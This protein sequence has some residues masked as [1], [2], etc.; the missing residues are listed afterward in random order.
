MLFHARQQKLDVINATGS[1]TAVHQ[2]HDFSHLPKGK[3]HR[4]QPESLTNLSL[5]G[6][7]ERMFTLYDTNRVIE[8]GRIVNPRWT[9]YRLLREISIFPLL[10]IKNSW[11]ARA[12]YTILNPG[13]AHRDKKKDQKM[14]NHIES[15]L[16]ESE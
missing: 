4:R 8:N 10:K 9:F 11:L 6:G 5:A 3:I 7:R 1:I 2:N 15:T 12:L 13:Q 16:K 14:K